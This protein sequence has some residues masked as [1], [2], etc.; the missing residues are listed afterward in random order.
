MDIVT[1]GERG[2]RAARDPDTDN[3]NTYAA[4]TIPDVEVVRKA[5]EHG[6]PTPSEETSLSRA[7]TQ[8]GSGQA[9][10][11]KEGPVKEGESAV[12]S[13]EEMAGIARVESVGHVLSKSKKAII[14]LALCV[15]Y[16]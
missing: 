14:V 4:M 16:P 15:C 12:A 2:T 3:L 5:E 7:S 11:L 9:D 6:H 1:E 13:T 8:A 10:R